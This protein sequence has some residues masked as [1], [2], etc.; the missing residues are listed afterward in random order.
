MRTGLAASTVTPGSTAPVVSLTA[1]DDRT[2]VIKLK[3]PN[4][5]IFPS[6]G[7]N[8]VGTMFVL[9]Q[10]AKDEKVLDVRRTRWAAC[11]RLP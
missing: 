7:S 1:A 4:S 2:I 5:T 6:L 9:P 3:E 10:E 8:A 11:Q